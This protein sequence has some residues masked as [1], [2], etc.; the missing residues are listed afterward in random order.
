MALYRP[1]H[2]A[3]EDRAAIAH[4]L[5]EYPFATLVTP[6]TP[7]PFVSHLPLLHVDDGS[8][9]GALIGHFAR[10]NPHARHARGVESLAIFHGP[11]AYVSPSWYREPARMV[12]T[13]NYV[14]VHARGTIE[15]IDDAAGAAKVLD[16][17][18]ERF[19]SGRAAPWQFRMQEPQ[20]SAMIG[21]I[22]AFRM[23]LRELVGKFKLSQNREGEDRARVARALREEGYSEADATAAWMEKYSLK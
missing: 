6:V 7:E 17:L 11:H 21:G 16:A 8:G 22:A 13:W 2:F 14:T 20:R 12:P 10:G 1:A 5:R 23:P 3:V 9:H 19:E 15:P 18:V 4:V